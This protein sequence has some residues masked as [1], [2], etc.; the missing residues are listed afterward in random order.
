M[1]EILKYFINSLSNSTL[2]LKKKGIF[3]EKPWALIDDD[4]EMQKLIFKKNGELVLS[5]NGKVT[6]GLWEYFAEAKS[7]LVNRGYDKLL[8]KEMFIDENVIIMKKD[9]TEND[10][11]TLANENTI[12]DLNV[13]KYLNTLKCKE[14]KIQE[15]KLLNGNILQVHE[16]NKIIH[17]PNYSGHRV[18]QVDD[19]Y[20]S[21]DLA[22]GVHITENRKTSFQ[23][24]N[25][26]ILS[27]H[28]NVLKKLT[29]DTFFEILDGNANYLKENLR[30]RV[31]INGKPI[32]DTRLEGIHNRVY[33]IRESSIAEILF[34]LKYELLDGT[35]IKI[36][37]K[38]ENKISKGDIIVEVM[39]N[40][41]LSDG[42]YKIKGRRG[43][44]KIVNMKIA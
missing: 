40:S 6:E 15:R 34:V 18:E 17:L 26:R 29:N 16:G 32:P 14:L 3:V 36:E 20:N 4:G 44:V 9:G 41:S 43:K 5:K 23:I 19:D 38:A 33:E 21:I 27:A 8:L 12:P 2:S 31:T 24:K 13:P 35:M 25:G 7:L 37:Q 28:N 42:K 10:F 30:K 1:N 11:Y 22:D 39:P